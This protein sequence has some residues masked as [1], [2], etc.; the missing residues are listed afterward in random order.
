MGLHVMGLNSVGVGKPDFKTPNFQ[1]L[2]ENL[3]REVVCNCLQN[4]GGGV[5]LSFLQEGSWT[6]LTLTEKQLKGST[7]DA[8]TVAVKR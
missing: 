8:T 5:P 6:T 3:S 1:T 7:G 2:Y 4:N